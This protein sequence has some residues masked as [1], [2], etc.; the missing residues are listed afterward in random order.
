M[1][2]FKPPQINSASV[3]ITR[4][5]IIIYIQFIIFGEKIIKSKEMKLYNNFKYKTRYLF[6]EFNILVILNHLASITRVY[7]TR[8]HILYTHSMC[9]NM[10]KH[11]LYYILSC[12]TWLETL[13]T[14]KHIHLVQIL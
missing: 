7:I 11:L 5:H 3:Y 9:V 8:T 13:Y 10:S 6:P 14:T 12:S 2:T 1:S 4:I